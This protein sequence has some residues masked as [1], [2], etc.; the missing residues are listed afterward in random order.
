MN[1]EAQKIASLEAKVRDLETA[2]RK[3]GAA[4]SIIG[5]VSALAGLVIGAFGVAF[6]V[7]DELGI[8]NQIKTV[9]ENDT[10]RS[11][12][13]LYD[14]VDLDPKAINALRDALALPDF[15]T[16]ALRSE[17]ALQREDALMVQAETLQK[18]WD[19]E[20]VFVTFDDLDYEF[21]KRGVLMDGDSVRIRFA[22]DKRNKYLDSVSFNV[23]T[24]DT[25]ALWSL[26]R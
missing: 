9:H 3:A 24:G 11:G 4:T 10:A 5:L 14:H 6:Y 12:V 25:Q 20:E 17:N 22:S 13:T 26:E 18:K 2:G 8:W 1:D 19:D 16:F 7:R 23:V 21:E 15:S